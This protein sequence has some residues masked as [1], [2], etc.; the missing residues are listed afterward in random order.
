M[1]TLNEDF[2][3]FGRLIQ[4][5]GTFEKNGSNNQEMTTWGRGYLDPV[6]ENPQA[7]AV[8]VWQIMNLTADTHPI[9]S[10]LENRSRVQRTFPGRPDG[11]TGIHWYHSPGEVNGMGVGRQIHDL[12]D[13][14]RSRLGILRHGVKIA[15]APGCHL[16]VV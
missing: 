10:H 3:E 8:E 16:L 12:P 15:T 9:P 7:G 1:L 14:Y 11:A 6:T 13:F 5:I 4:T 2:D